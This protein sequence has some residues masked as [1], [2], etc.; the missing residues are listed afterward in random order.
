MLETLALEK[1]SRSISEI[2]ASDPATLKRF[3]QLEGKSLQL[4]ILKTPVNCLATFTT[5]GVHLSK[6]TTK[7]HAT[8]CL[9]GTPSALLR[10]A[11]TDAH[12]QMLMDKTIKIH[13]DLDML[14]EIKKI[15]QHLHIDWEGLLAGFIGDFAANRFMLAA[16]EFKTRLSAHVKSFGQSSQDYVHYEA[17]LLPTQDEVQH[18]YDELRDFRRDV[19]RLEAQLRKS[20]VY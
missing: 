10:F 16:K 17:K 7:T 18:F 2:L 1:I 11:K 15:Q 5:T 4:H 12:T 13:G 20:H 9:T 6:A 8:V 3:T 19:D 14:L